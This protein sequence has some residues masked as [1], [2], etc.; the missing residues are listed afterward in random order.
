MNGH[1]GAQDDW[2]QRLK[3]ELRNLKA[4]KPDRLVQIADQA[5][6]ELRP[7]KMNQ[8]R[9][10]LDG[11]RRLE[12]KQ[13]GSQA[14]VADLQ[15]DLHMLRPKLAYAVGR[16]DQREKPH[17]V[18]L[19]NILDPAIQAAAEDPKECFDKLLRLVEGI[20]AYHR[21]HGGN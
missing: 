2:A 10:F 3:S 13:K 17:F 8:I 15:A 18:A 12:S 19:M 6:K 7:I 1:S 16:A 11:V 4:V 21:F 5:G 14:H 9:R 20:I